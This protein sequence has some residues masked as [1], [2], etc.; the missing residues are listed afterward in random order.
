MEVKFRSLAALSILLLLSFID[1]EEGQRCM[2]Q[3]FPEFFF[4]F[5]DCWCKLYKCV[6]KLTIDVEECFFAK[7]TCKCVCGKMFNSSRRLNG[8]SKYRIS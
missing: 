4:C 1:V 5:K 7:E 3:Y 8:C 6:K 2:D